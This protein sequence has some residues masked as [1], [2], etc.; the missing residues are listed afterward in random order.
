MCDWVKIAFEFDGSLK[1]VIMFQDGH[2]IDT[3]DK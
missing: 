1:H 3:W 2:N